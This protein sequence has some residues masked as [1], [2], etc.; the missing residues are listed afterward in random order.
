[1]N[2]PRERIVKIEKTQNFKNNKK[3]NCTYEQLLKNSTFP[4]L[5]ADFFGNDAFFNVTFD[6]KYISWCGGA[7]NPV[8]CTT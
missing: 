3:V 2:H 8:G 1:M 6:V 4:D 5:L 7:I